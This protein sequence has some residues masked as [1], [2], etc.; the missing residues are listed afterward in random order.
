MRDAAA[1]RAAEALV[2]APQQ[3]QTTVRVVLRQQA[4]AATGEAVVCR[5]RSRPGAAAP[6]LASCPH[7]IACGK[8]E[9]TVST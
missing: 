3:P 4:P 8:K 9:A 7:S 6:Q 2:S 1:E 5:S